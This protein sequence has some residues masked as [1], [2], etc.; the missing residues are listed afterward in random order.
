MLASSTDVS[1]LST[2]RGKLTLALLCSVAL[3]GFRRRLDRQR[4]AA[5]DPPRS[6]LLGPEPA[7]GAQR[8]PADLRR[9]HAARRPRC[10]PPWTPPAADRRHLAVRPLVARRGPGGSEAMLIG[11]RLVQGLG[12]AMTFPAASRSSPP[13]ST[14]ATTPQGPRGVGRHRRSRLRSW[15][16]PRRR[17]CQWPGWRWVFFVNLPVCVSCSCGAFRLL[18]R[19]AAPLGSEELRRR[20]RGLATGGCCCSSTRSSRRLTSA[21]APPRTIGGLAEPARCWPHLLLNET[22]RE[23]LSSRS[24]S[25]AY[26]ASPPPTLRR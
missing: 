7:V 19:R 3:L 20:R 9:L 26:R 5:V 24:R 2:R 11:A 1:F 23:T 12:A 18:E 17:D 8:L 10:R 4:R 14:R 16:V 25:S 22:R 6:A 13:P 21:G 15:R